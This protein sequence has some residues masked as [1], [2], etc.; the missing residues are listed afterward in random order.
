M[1]IASS[2]EHERLVALRQELRRDLMAFGVPGQAWPRRWNENAAFAYTVKSPAGVRIQVLC[3][4][5]AYLVPRP[6]PDT[7]VYG[8]T[9]SAMIGWRGNAAGAWEEAKRVAQ[10]M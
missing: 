6:H 10:W 3:R 5:E 8:V 1:S 7:Y 9:C 4:V 2:S